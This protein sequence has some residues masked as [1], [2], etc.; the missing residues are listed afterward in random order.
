METQTHPNHIES[1]FERAGE[2]LEMRSD[3]F[4]LKTADKTAEIVSSI[5]ARLV[6]ALF[7]SSCFLMFNIGLAILIGYSIGKVY[8]GFFIVAAFYA[9]L[10]TILYSLRHQWLEGPISNLI[11]KSIFK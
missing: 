3:L 11:I 4:K 10:I 9:I 6:I 5:V 7:V 1:L 8:Y 2:Y